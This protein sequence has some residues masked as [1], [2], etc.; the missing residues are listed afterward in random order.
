M[1]PVVVFSPG[2]RVRQAGGERGGGEAKHLFSSALPRVL[3]VAGGTR[4]FAWV[5]GKECAA[6]MWKYSSVVI[7]CGGGREVEAACVW[8]KKGRKIRTIGKGV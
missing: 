2:P 3:C 4:R 1:L 8:R 6:R 5:I 7:T